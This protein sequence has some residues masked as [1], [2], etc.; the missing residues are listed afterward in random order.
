M[1]VGRV[2]GAVV[3]AEVFPAAALDG[4]LGQ[5]A[6]APPD[7]L[8]RLDHDAFA[9]ALGQPRPPRTASC[10]APAPSLTTALVRSRDKPRWSPE[11]SRGPMRSVP[12]APDRGTAVQPRRH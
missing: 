3:D 4:R 7:A 5:A 1:L 8:Q 12:P 10:E 6:A 9:A 11:W 2:V